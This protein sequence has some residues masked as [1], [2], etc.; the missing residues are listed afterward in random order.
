MYRAEP[1]PNFER[2][3]KKLMKRDRLRYERVRKKI[4]EVC[5]EPHRYEPLGNVMAGTRRVHI[6]PYV[7][8]FEIDETTKTVRLLDFDHHDKIYKN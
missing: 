7:F 5:E 1:S 4:I 3:M 6:D 8:T 2:K